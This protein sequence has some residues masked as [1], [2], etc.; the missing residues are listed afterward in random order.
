MRDPDDA[1]NVL[2]FALRTV[3][4]RESS[5]P[6]V[7]FCLSL[8]HSL[9]LLKSQTITRLERLEPSVQIGD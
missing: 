4:V 9:P 7:S 1:D 3:L 2:L 8:R 6:H 5:T